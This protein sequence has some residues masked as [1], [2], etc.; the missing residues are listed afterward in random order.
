MYTC[1]LDCHTIC[2]PKDARPIWLHLARL[3]HVAY[4]CSTTDRKKRRRV[5]YVSAWT[6]NVIS[7]S[8]AAFPSAV[9]QCQVNARLAQQ[10]VQ[11]TREERGLWLDLYTHLDALH[12]LRLDMARQNR[13]IRCTGVQYEEIKICTPASS[14][15]PRSCLFCPSSSI[16]LVVMKCKALVDRIRPAWACRQRA[17]TLHIP[18][19]T[20]MSGGGGYKR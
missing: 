2:R 8:P 7:H 11:L 15:L 12:M 16:L 17:D 4:A 20:R 6:S 18:K 14:I 5:G 9:Y 1:R 3:D 19:E 10:S 13:Q